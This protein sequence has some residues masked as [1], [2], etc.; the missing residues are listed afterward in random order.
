MRLNSEAER[1]ATLETEVSTDPAPCDSGCSS[2]YLT[3]ALEVQYEDVRQCPQAELD[4]ALLE[5]LAVRAA[6][7]VIGGQL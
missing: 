1:R 7:G 3:E 6:P 2:P 4:A 5:L